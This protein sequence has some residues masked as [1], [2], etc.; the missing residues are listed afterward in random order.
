MGSSSLEGDA[1][2]SAPSSHMDSRADTQPALGWSMAG[3]QHWCRTGPKEEPHILGNDG[4]LNKPNRK[5][6]AGIWLWQQGVSAPGPGNYSGS[7]AQTVGTVQSVLLL[8]RG[9]SPTPESPAALPAHPR[10]RQPKGAGLVQ[11]SQVLGLSGESSASHPLQGCK[12]GALAMETVTDGAH[13]AWDN[14]N[15]PPPLKKGCPKL[16]WLPGTL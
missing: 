12:T 5:P 15:P 3:A 16:G 6:S 2:E 11:S 1:E 13:A 4:V 9:E 8:L 10:Q 7:Q 14:A